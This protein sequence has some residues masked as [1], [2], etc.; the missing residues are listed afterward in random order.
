[1]NADVNK[2]I[3][4]TNVA[5]GAEARFESFQQSQGDVASWIAGPLA[6]QGKDVGNRNNL[7]IYAEVESDIT[8]DLLLAAA[9][10]F[11][12]YSDFGGDFSY[13]AAA[14]YKI[15]E[16][17]A[18]RASINR[19]FRA[20]SLAQFHYSN[21][22]QIAF[23]D[24]GNS[25]VTPFLPIRDALVQE[26]FGVTTL[27]PETSFDIA[28]G[29]TSKINEQL[30]LTV[31]AYQ[32]DID[33]R[34]V[35]SGGINAADFSQFDGAGYDEINIFTNAINTRTQGLDIVLDYKTFFAENNS[36]GLSLAA[37]FNNTDTTGINSPGVFG[38]R[39]LN[40]ID[41]RDI[42]FLTDGVP[43]SK[44]IISGNYQIGKFSVLARAT[45]FGEVQDARE[46]NPETELPQVFSA[47]IITDLSLTGH[48][49]EKFSVT[50]GANNLF[51]VYPDMLLSPNVR[52]EV[53]YS[54]RTNQFG[55][56]GRFINLAL[57]YNW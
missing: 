45:R 28:L 27:K 31:D 29:I 6:T 47:K 4:N 44:I 1:M 52:G 54:R 57:N 34:V 55:T 25:V 49:N 16:Q 51:D 15:S 11:E 35:V 40:I 43:N 30:S 19:S 42:T 3:G 46:V 20:P 37:N 17:L 2:L 10:R 38:E 50:V 22:A 48:V 53:I 41:G 13:K 9:V 24:D 5:F 23:D 33:D 36:L 26:A 18:A 14:R 39:G 7:G 32:I 8:E 12:N 21:F 56:Q